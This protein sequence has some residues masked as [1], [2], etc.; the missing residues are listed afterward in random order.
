MITRYEKYLGIDAE[1]NVINAGFEIR[2]GMFSA[3]F[4]T[5][6]PIREAD[7]D[8]DQMIED[9]YTVEALGQELA[10]H[11]CE[12]F[13]CAPSKIPE[14]VKEDYAIN[15]YGNILD[16]ID[17]SLFPEE[18]IVNGDIWFF[19]SESCG[20][21]DI[22]KKGDFIAPADDDA[23]CE[24][25]ELWQLKH[26]STLPDEGTQLRKH[27]DAKIQSIMNALPDKGSDEVMEHI[28]AQIERSAYSPDGAYL[29]YDPARIEPQTMQPPSLK[30]EAK[31]ARAAS[32]ELADLQPTRSHDRQI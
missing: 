31:A 26:L 20:Q 1:G 23:I 12:R 8:L 7:Y 27:F 10:F 21:I 22:L 28:C 5:S 6:R 32:K 18:V 2:D 15:G 29:G 16:L 30:E 4:D 25:Y 14:A 11:L 13:D 24:L 19:E 17:C 9:R 3:S